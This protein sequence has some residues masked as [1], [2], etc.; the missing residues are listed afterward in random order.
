MGFS[1]GSVSSAL[2]LVQCAYTLFRVGITKTSLHFPKWSLCWPVGHLNLAPRMMC[3]DPSCVFG[4]TLSAVLSASW[5]SDS[6]VLCEIVYS[7]LLDQVLSSG[8]WLLNKRSS[9]CGGW[10]GDT[11]LHLSGTT[12]SNVVNFVNVADDR[13]RKKEENADEK[14]ARPIGLILAFHTSSFPPR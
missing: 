6:P 13:A 12:S 2:F 9:I 10:P 7:M 11:T 3:L 8:V 14:I 4:F 1:R 5:F